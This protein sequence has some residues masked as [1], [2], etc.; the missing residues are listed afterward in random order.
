MKE[1]KG[2]PTVRTAIIGGRMD[3]FPGNLPNLSGPQP[4]KMKSGIWTQTLPI[5]VTR[6]GEGT[7]LCKLPGGREF[8]QEKGRN[9]V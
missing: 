3:V 8:Q 5:A 2:K 7:I 6:G 9:G 1:K 4:T